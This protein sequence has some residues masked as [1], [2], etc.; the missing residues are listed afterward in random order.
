M[1]PPFIVDFNRIHIYRIGFWNFVD[2]YL[3]I[4]FFTI[5]YLGI[6]AICM[7]YYWPAL[8]LRQKIHQHV[9]LSVYFRQIIYNHQNLFLWNRSLVSCFPAYYFIFHI[10]NFISSD[11][12]IFIWINFTS[13]VTFIPAYISIRI[14]IDWL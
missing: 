1:I 9:I 14:S 7:K 12:S 8:R 11:I 2:P 10:T 4:M 6:V 13:I 3:R 5:R